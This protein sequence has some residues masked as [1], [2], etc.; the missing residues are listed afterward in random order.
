MQRTIIISGLSGAGKSSAAKVLE[1]LGYYVVDNLPTPLV[2]S[3]FNLFSKPFLKSYPFVALVVD[4]RDQAHIRSLPQKI[5]SLR[6]RM[7]MLKLDVLFFKASTDVLIRRFSQTRHRHPLSGDGPLLD[8]IEKERQM[9][10]QIREFADQVIDTSQWTS[11]ELVQ[12]LKHAFGERTVSP[13]MVIS[14]LSFGF[15]YGLPLQADLIFDVRFLKNPFFESHLKEKTG[16]DQEVNDYVMKQEPAKA[17][18]EKIEGLLMFLIPKYMKES[19]SYLT[20]GVGCTG[21]KHRSVTVVNHLSNILQNNQ[22]NVQVIHRDI[23]L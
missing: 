20:L 23:D 2:E 21:G 16:M 9:L 11:Q 4:A 7:P 3:F 1:D 13:K 18:M 14:M 12:Y 22:I 8:G 10:T 15:R 19:K 5:K 6:E 17:F